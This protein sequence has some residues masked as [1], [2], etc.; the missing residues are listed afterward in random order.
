M[1]DAAPSMRAARGLSTAEL[2]KYL[3]ANGWSVRP[4]R[5]DGMSIV[6][7]D[8]PGADRA[9]EFILPV[10]PGFDEEQRRVADALRTLAQLEG[11]AEATIA[12]DILVD[13]HKKVEDIQ[14]AEKVGAARS[15]RYRPAV[16]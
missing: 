8:I 13:G 16:G 9:A 7:K 2:L 14:R 6:S 1:I 15:G 4:S 5:V 12:E 10:K 3:L 11:R